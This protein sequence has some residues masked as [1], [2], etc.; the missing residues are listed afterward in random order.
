MLWTLK[1]SAN[2]SPFISGASLIPLKLRE[3]GGRAYAIYYSVHCI[4]PLHTMLQT[5]NL[6]LEIVKE[7]CRTADL[8]NVVPVFTEI[9]GAPLQKAQTGRCFRVHIMSSTVAQ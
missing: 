7:N 8:G 1:G 9:G 5:Y 3:R 4:T 6:V 2:H